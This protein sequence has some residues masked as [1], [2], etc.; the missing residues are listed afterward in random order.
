MNHPDICLKSASLEFRIDPESS[1]WTLLDLSNGQ[2]LLFSDTATLFAPFLNGAAVDMK[3]V[4]VESRG[5]G[6]RVT[7]A[8]SGVSQAFV[9]IEMPEGEDALDFQ[10][11]FTVD[12]AAQLNRL[13]VLPP[14]TCINM[15]DVV[16]FRNRHQTPNTWP[17]LLLGPG[18]QTD[19]Y[20]TDW[21]FAP[22]PTAMLFRKNE[23]HLFL[24]ALDLPKSYGL[25]FAAAEYKIKH[26][27]L[28]YGE[29]PF[30][31]DLTAGTVFKSPRMRL[32][33]RHKTEPCRMYAEFGE[34]LV[35]A[36]RIPDPKKKNRQAWWL[37][38]LYCTWID[39]CF[40]SDA[41]IPIELSEQAKQ[42]SDPAGAVLTTKL[43]HDAVKVIQREKLPVRTILID[44][45]WSVSAG[46]WEPHPQ[47]LP[48]FRKLVD[49]L[50]AQGFKVV[51]WWNWAE[52]QAS[53]Q[54]D[55][56]HLVGGGKLNRHGCRV[57]D[58][59]SPVTQEEY[60]KPLFRKLFSGDPDSLDLDGVK[61]DFLADKVHPEM[62]LANPDW[63]GE[64]NYF[65]QVT[66]LFYAEMK[67]H[68]PDAVH[69][70]CAGDYWLAEYIDINRTYDVASSD[71]REHENR[72]RMLMA[73]CPGCPVAYDFHNHIENFD[74]WLYSARRIK[75]SIQLGNVL[76]VKDDGFSVPRVADASY[77]TTIRKHLTS[78]W[79]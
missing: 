44:G 22:H 54:A 66:K 25:Y 42:T 59:S 37:E 18:C 69:I 56:A 29:Q 50:H 53:A 8:G 40:K 21:Q 15:F 4:R 3:A 72:G 68:K 55:P 67:R 58:Y 73:T 13:D 38:P 9:D 7:L 2:R 17:E 57:R 11:Q 63:R 61:T 76:F 75:A 60:L 31:Q 79:W 45:G 24:A 77:F 78:P 62:P 28:N 51:V 70:G 12:S 23:A 43:V 49:E 19:T 10:A 35:R 16:N 65:F 52:V 27:Y 46:Q 71:W 5:S 48:E 64:E 1:C 26:C 14:Q 34:M 39:Q 20:S 47:R 32:F 6:A 74:E 36:G 30:G 33:L 41:R